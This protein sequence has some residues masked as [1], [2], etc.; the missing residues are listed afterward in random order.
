MTVVTNVLSAADNCIFD[1]I[2]ILYWKYYYQ[3]E[4]GPY[5][6]QEIPQPVTS[7]N[8]LIIYFATD[9]SVTR[10]GFIFD[11]DIEG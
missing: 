4:L 2:T 5:C 6:G 7:R 8:K 1:N 10:R 3:Q 11:Y 9:S